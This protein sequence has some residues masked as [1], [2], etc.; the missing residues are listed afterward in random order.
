MGLG[1]EE[2]VIVWI[3]KT[4]DLFQNIVYQE[5]QVFFLSTHNF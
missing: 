4:F 3:A 5:H 1:P 2:I